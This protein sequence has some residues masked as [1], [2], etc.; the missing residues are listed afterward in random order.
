MQTRRKENQI[1]IIKFSFNSSYFQIE[2]T[3]VFSNNGHFRI[4]MEL[5]YFYL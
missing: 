4:A 2:G 3:L 1:I 5:P